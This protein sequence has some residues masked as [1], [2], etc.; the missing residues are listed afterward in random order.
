MKTDG[1]FSTFHYHACAHVL[2]ARF[3]R[4]LQHLV[5]V[6]GATALST[7][8]GHGHASV[9]DF[10]FQDFITCRK[11]YSHVSGSKHEETGSH[12]TL[13]TAVAEGLNILDIITADRVV[14]RLASSHPPENDE[15]E[16]TL[17]GSKFENLRVAGCPVDVELDFDF[18]ERLKTFDAVRKEFDKNA[19]F[20]KIAEDPF[21]TGDAIKKPEAHGVLL[22]S[23]VKSM[24]TSCPGV[25]QVGHCFVVPEFGKVFFGELI[26]KHGLRTLTMIRFELGS[27]VS[28]DGTLVQAMANGNRF[29]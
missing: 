7:N 28:G 18:F 23:L 29:P 13:V 22:C 27:P 9:D 21:R 1:G 19:E 11:G 16:I 20:R 26:L 4:P 8:G 12:T 25:K 17:V 15:P 6:Q 10:R 5:E 3:T 2:S 24:K 14:A